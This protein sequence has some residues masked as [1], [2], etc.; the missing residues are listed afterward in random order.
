[1]LVLGKHDNPHI[2]C[3]KTGYQ[4]KVVQLERG[5][6]WGPNHALNSKPESSYQILSKPEGLA[7]H[8]S[9]RKCLVRPWRSEG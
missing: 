1:M 2:Y 3:D 5:R 7:E 6:A 8:S 9:V 4:T